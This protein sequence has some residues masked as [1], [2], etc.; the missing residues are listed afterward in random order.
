MN[1]LTKISFLALVGVAIGWTTSAQPQPGALSSLRSET[2]PASMLA[3]PYGDASAPAATP[4]C[5]Y[6]ERC[7]SGGTENAQKCCAAYLKR[8]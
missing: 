1:K 2:A 4:M 8:C 6:L 7:C 5:N 3:C